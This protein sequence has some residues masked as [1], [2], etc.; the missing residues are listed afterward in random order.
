L[1]TLPNEKFAAFTE[2]WLR[3]GKIVVPSFF[4]KMEAAERI[5]GHGRSEPKRIKYY[6]AHARLPVET[7]ETSPMIIWIGKPAPAI[8]C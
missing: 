5:A 2:G 6:E 3:K 1:K 4:V 7:H 8:P